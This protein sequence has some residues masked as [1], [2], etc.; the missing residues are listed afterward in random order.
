LEVPAPGPYYD[1]AAWYEH[2]STPGAIGPA[3]IIGH[4]DSAANG[5][6]VFFHL[7]DLRPGQE[8]LITRADGL[9]AVFRVDGVG[10]YPKLDFPTQLVYGE[11][12]HAALR[13]ITCGG[14]FDRATGH[15]QDNII[16]FASL[17]GSHP[18]PGTN[19]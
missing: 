13:L 6:S 14:T 4:V 3:V 17:I 7:R 2:S 8:I 5:P 11:T 1:D 9:V 16:V 19:Q 12:D 15:Y 10:A 18:T